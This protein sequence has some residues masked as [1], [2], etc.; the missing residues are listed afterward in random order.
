MRVDDKG[1]NSR[2]WDEEII[3]K[4]RKYEKGEVIYK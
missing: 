1:R 3:N 4:K 2:R